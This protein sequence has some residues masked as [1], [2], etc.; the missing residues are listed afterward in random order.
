MAEQLWRKVNLGGETKRVI[1]RTAAKDANYD[2]E[3]AHD[4]ISQ[5]LEKTR[6]LAARRLGVEEVAKSLEETEF[7]GIMQLALMQER[8][9]L[10]L[11]RGLYLQSE[12][13]RVVDP[14]I[15]RKMHSA[16]GRYLDEIDRAEVEGPA[17]EKNPYGHFAIT[18]HELVHKVSYFE[19]NPAIGQN[20]YRL[21]YRMRDG[22]GVGLDEAMTEGLNQELLRAH[23]GL[24]TK[25]FGAPR[26]RAGAPCATWAEQSP[27]YEGYQGT[28][29]EVCRMVDTY[30]YDGKPT[31]WDNLKRGHQGGVGRALTEIRV[32][33][34]DSAYPL[35]MAMGNLNF[36]DL[37]ACVKDYPTMGGTDAAWL[38]I[39]A[40]INMYFSKSSDAGEKRVLLDHT[41]R[42]MQRSSDLLKTEDE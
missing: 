41:A 21:G 38:L 18:S 8:D 2:A 39:S 6:R 10:G 1:N 14:A 42:Y 3:K 27:M 4:E 20:V 36:F 16:Q 34:G 30:L 22:R 26:D 23:S 19:T 33:L 17:K 29:K 5:K 7:I 28:T 13:V 12:R 32:V 11:P 31:T 37:K 25:R 35:F 9:R 24:L 40:R 15:W